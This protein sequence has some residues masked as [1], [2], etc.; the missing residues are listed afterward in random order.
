M[1][2]PLVEVS[3]EGDSVGAGAAAVFKDEG[4]VAPGAAEG[5]AVAQGAVDLLTLLGTG[6]LA[7]VLYSLGARCQRQMHVVQEWVFRGLR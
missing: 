6:V 1:G 2:P 3:E 4:D 7:G 5:D